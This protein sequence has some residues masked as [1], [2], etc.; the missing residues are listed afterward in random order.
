M[1]MNITELSIYTVSTYMYL[2]LNLSVNKY[3]S[4][5]LF[6]GLYFKFSVPL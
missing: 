2:S 6:P 5:Q 1:Y 3:D 4:H